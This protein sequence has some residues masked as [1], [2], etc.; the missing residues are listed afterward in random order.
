MVEKNNGEKTFTSYWVKE[1]CSHQAGEK[2]TRNEEG[3]RNGRRIKQTT[4]IEEVK[5]KGKRTR[6]LMSGGRV[7]Q[8]ETLVSI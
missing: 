4:G 1:T 2:T 5:E 8:R 7:Y 3:T 6:V